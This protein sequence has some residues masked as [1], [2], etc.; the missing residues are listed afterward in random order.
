MR[1]HTGE[2]PYKCSFNGCGFSAASKG[3]LSY[4]KRKIHNLAPHGQAQNITAA[5]DNDNKDQG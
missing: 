5:D 3:S 2:K 1:T 4:H